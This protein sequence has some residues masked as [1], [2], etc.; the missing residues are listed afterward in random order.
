M[1]LVARRR[2]IR[3]VVLPSLVAAWS[4]GAAGAARAQTLYFED[5]PTAFDGQG[6]GGDGCWTNH[7]RLTDLD[8]DGDL[9]AI[10]PNASGFFA[11]PGAQPLEIWQNDGSGGFA[12]ATDALLGGPVV[13]P[14]RVVAV[15]D[16]DGDGDR[17]IVAPSA[18]GLPDRLFVQQ[19]DGA[20]VDEGPRRLASSSRS[21]AVRLGDVD[22]DGDLDLI[23]AQ[24]YAA[25][26]SPPARLLENDGTGHFTPVAG[27]PSSV[28]GEDVD[29]LD[30]FDAD[31]D[32]DL[33]V[34]VNVHVGPDALWINDGTGVFADGSD[35]LP[36]PEDDGFHYGPTACDLDGDGDRDL[37]IDNIGPGYTEQVLINDGTGSFTAESERL[38]GNTPHDDNGLVCL[39][40]DQDGDQDVIVMSLSS[41]GERLFLN[42]GDGQLQL[43]TG[44]FTGLVDPTLWMEAGDVDGDG[45]LDVVTA[46]GEGSP[47]AERLYLGTDAVVQ[48]QT[49]P[50]IFAWNTSAFWPEVRFAI[51]DAASSD[52]GPRV[53][54]VEAQVPNAESPFPATAMGGDLF[55]VVVPEDTTELTLCASDLAGNRGCIDVRPGSGEGGGGGAGGSEPVGPGAGGGA[56]VGST[57]AATGGVTTSTGDGAG[58]GAEGE[59]GGGDGRAILDR[60]CGCT[61]VGT[62]IEG[63]SALVASVLGALACTAR[64]R[65]R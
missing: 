8:G 18:A 49:P 17:D 44:A 30:L 33:D 42:D 23:V 24:G 47:E 50:V 38:G 58:G 31:G 4:L 34:L 63:R 54:D 28:A 19:P 57:S 16:V 10:F 65:R 43:A 45:R 9:D 27:L 6:C 22:G 32:F 2:L 25:P 5:A 7:L 61:I 39:D 20:F 55:R 37:L 56:T 35:A 15:G 40:V 11:S 62:P 64:R 26:D 1:K 12:L 48:D 36:P 14:I 41:S 59:G 29:D 21:A 46:Q 52:E 51:R 13:A 60:G 53:R 3:A